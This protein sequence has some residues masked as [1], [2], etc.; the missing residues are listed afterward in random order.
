[1]FPSLQVLPPP[2]SI[3]RSPPLRCNGNR[4]RR[5]PH[6]AVTHRAHTL[7]REN[8][9][10]A[11]GVEFGIDFVF[12]GVLLLLLFILVLAITGSLL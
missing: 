10:I 7:S 11:T 2:L 3:V 1:M 5:Q 8:E 12:L 9:I 6:R 4:I